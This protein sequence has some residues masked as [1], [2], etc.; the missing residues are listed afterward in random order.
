VAGGPAPDVT[1]HKS[2]PA[3]ARAGAVFTYSITVRNRSAFAA[4]DVEVTDLVPIQLTLV[5][6]PSGATIRNGVV[7]WR[8]GTLAAGRSRTLRMQ[9]R[10]NPNV[11]GLIRNTATVT[12]EGMPP[13]RST[14]VTRVSGPAPVARTGGVTG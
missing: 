8:V 14:A 11:T 7:T 1:I 2:G 3:R 5:R 13:K 6:I 4:T 12:A 9:V 10:V